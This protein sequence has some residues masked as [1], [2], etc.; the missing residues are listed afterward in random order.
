MLPCQTLSEVK[1]LNTSSTIY[2]WSYCDA[3]KCYGENIKWFWIAGRN[4]KGIIRINDKGKDDHLVSD[5]NYNKNDDNKDDYNYDHDDM[6]LSHKTI[7]RH[8]ATLF[9]RAFKLCLKLFGSLLKLCS[10]ILG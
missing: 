6:I 9:S 1:Q 5:S 7:Q 3:M 10:L 8:P 4:G 2:W